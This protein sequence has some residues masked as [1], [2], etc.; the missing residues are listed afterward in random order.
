MS[1]K[2]LSNPR[3]NRYVEVFFQDEEKKLI[4]DERT[5]DY[6]RPFYPWAKIQEN[7]RMKFDGSGTSTKGCNEG[8]RRLFL[9]W[10]PKAKVE[11]SE[12]NFRKVENLQSE[13]YDWL[14]RNFRPTGGNS[15]WI[16]CRMFAPF[17]KEAK[18]KKADLLVLVNA[19]RLC[20]M[21]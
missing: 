16:N 11:W 19:S 4:I 1:W 13:K 7:G 8:Y 15:G 14:Q 17:I 20:E 10:E 6:N 9:R 12:I 3:A 18:K 5:G 2:G 21:D